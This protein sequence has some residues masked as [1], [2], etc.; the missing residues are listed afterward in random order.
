MCLKE[1]R[2]NVKVACEGR[3]TYEAETAKVHFTEWYD[4]SGLSVE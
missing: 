1:G 2:E 3:L 4:A